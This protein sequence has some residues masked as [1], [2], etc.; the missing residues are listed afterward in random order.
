MQRTLG[1][2]GEA[3][4]ESVINTAIHRGIS[5]QD[6]IEIVKFIWN[7]ELEEMKVK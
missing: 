6:F 4:L 7:Q 2:A 5:Y 1:F 3:D